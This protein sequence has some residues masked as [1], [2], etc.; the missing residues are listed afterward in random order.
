MDRSGRTK[1]CLTRP[2]LMFSPLPDK[3]RQGQLSISGIWQTASSQPE[4]LQQTALSEAV[5]TAPRDNQ[6][7][8]QPNI[9]QRS[10]LQL[11]GQARR[12]G[13]VEDQ[14]GLRVSGVDALAARARRAGEPPRQ[15]GLRDHDRT[16]P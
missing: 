16:V 14:L 9:E 6:V 12:A 10:R 5:L 1:S 8:V 2:I 4:L 7:I 15:L 11:L 3:L 13:E